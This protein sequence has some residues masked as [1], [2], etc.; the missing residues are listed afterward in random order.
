MGIVAG[1]I[2]EIVLR[3]VD[4]LIRA[5]FDDESWGLL[6]GLVL[7][8]SESLNPRNVGVRHWQSRPGVSRKTVTRCE[9]QEEIVA[10]GVAGGRERD[11]AQRAGAEGVGRVIVFEKLDVR[12][13]LEAHVTVR[14][15]PDAGQDAGGAHS[16]GNPVRPWE[17]VEAAH[18]VGHQVRHKQ[19]RE[20]PKRKAVGAGAGALLDGMNGALNLANVAV[21]RDNVDND[22]QEGR[23]DAR[24]LMV[25]VHVGDGQAAGLV[26][27]DDT[28]EHAHDGGFGAVADGVCGA[29]TDA[30][31][32]GVEERNPLYKEKIHTERDNPMVFKYG[33]GD[34]FGHKGG[35][36]GGGR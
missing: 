18:G 20:P 13:K 1:H 17:S 30:A 27:G 31:R 14:G 32:D 28:A 19:A 29:K 25:T 15:E 4:G 22:G 36:P 2:I 12:T 11:S 7:V 24:K 23:T 8:Q 3:V 33:G 35:C 6:H 9:R 26:Q 10:L 34:G 16:D 5:P 21:R